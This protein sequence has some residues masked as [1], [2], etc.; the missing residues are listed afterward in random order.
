MLSTAHERGSWDRHPETVGDGSGT[1]LVGVSDVHVPT[2]REL[3]LPTLQAIQDLGGS[4]A[5]SEVDEAAIKA[6]GITESQL[7]VEFPPEARQ[8]GP[9]VIHRLAFAR[10][11]LKAFDALGNSK[12]GVWTI[13]PVGSKYLAMPPEE[14]VEALKKADNALRAKWRSRRVVSEAHAD[15]GDSDEDELL[16]EAASWRDELLALLKAMDPEGFERLCMRL[17]RE[18]GFR[19]V[20][21]TKRSGDGGID[22]V[23]VYRV[24]LVS[25]PTYFQA[26]RYSG[27]VGARVVRD[28]RGAMMGRGEKGLVIT[29]GTFTPSATEEAIRDGAPP[30]DLIDGEALCDLLKRYELGLAVTE[31]VEEDVAVISSYFETV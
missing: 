10:S 14:A 5:N 19:N 31:R 26:K 13:T 4:A 3:M 12:R 20:E 21:V 16:E 25:F 29:T 24:S 15:N 18:A 6:A 2:Y 30:I 28:F 8:T 23:G 11:Y 9:K 27:S 17:L 7:A 1:T 22:G